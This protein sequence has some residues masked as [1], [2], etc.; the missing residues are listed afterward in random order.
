ME[1]ENSLAGRVA[2]GGWLG[3]ATGPWTWVLQRTLEEMS[4]HSV[5]KI[6]PH[7]DYSCG[8]TTS[9]I[10]AVTM[11]SRPPTLPVSDMCALGRRAREPAGLLQGGV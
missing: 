5:S 3:T 2:G 6:V 8:L 7:P 4:L 9:D 1:I 11:H 10:T